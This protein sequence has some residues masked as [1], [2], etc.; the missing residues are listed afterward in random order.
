MTTR[1][2]RIL[3]VSLCIPC[4]FAGCKKVPYQK[5]PLAYYPTVH[6]DAGTV[7]P[8]GSVTI[9]G[10]VEKTGAG[11]IYYV[12]VC[13][14]SAPNPEMHINQIRAKDLVDN[15]FSVRYER[16]DARKSYHFRAFAC[17]AYG[18]AYGQ[19]VRVERP[20]MDT[21]TIPCHPATNMISVDYNWGAPKQENMV[22]LNPLDEADF[23][24]SAS[25]YPSSYEISLRFGRRPTTGKYKI[26]EQAD[27]GSDLV[28]AS[29]NNPNDGNFRFDNGGE[30]YVYQLDQR[31]IKVWLCEQKCGLRKITAT[32]VSK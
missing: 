8:D 17:N 23:E 32:F 10:S 20:G 3:A 16:L 15:R 12:G 2:L 22:Y 6:T 4:A 27:R 26:W 24:V 9:G 30:L 25:S 21:N 7:E 11:E 19:D 31:R 13:M 5:D 14:D 29:F 1:S 18:Y 28:E